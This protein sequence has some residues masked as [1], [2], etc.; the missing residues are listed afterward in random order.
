MRCWPLRPTW[1]LCRRRVAAAAIPGGRAALAGRVPRATS[2]DIQLRLD[3][4]LPGIFAPHDEITTPVGSHRSIFETEAPY[5][6][7]GFGGGQTSLG[8]FDFF[9]V[10]LA[11][12]MGV[13]EGP[14]QSLPVVVDASA[15]L[16]AGPDYRGVLGPITG[17][18]LQVPRRQSI[19]QILACKPDGLSIIV[20][21]GLG[22]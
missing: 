19:I 20:R 6:V 21:S 11:R 22:F 5:P 3:A 7:A 4:P 14:C 13:R 2:R 12:K 8:H 16:A 17:V 18:V 9:R 10:T 1:R 15:Q